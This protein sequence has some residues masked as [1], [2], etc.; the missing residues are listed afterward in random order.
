MLLGT[1]YYYHLLIYRLS[2]FTSWKNFFRVYLWYWWFGMCWHVCI[3]ESYVGSV[4]RS[5]LPNKKCT[6]RF[7]W[8][9]GFC[10]GRIMVQLS[11]FEVICYSSFNASAADTCS[12]PLYSLI[13]CFRITCYLLINKNENVRSCVLNFGTDLK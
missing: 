8:I 3:N 2:P 1:L 9:F 13:F 7:I 4:K 5:I 10:I 12:I 6:I 11:Q